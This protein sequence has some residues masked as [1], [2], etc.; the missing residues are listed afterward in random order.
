VSDGIGDIQLNINVNVRNAAGLNAINNALAQMGKTNASAASAMNTTS[1]AT[2]QQMTLMQGLHARLDQAERDYDAIFRA[3]YRLQNVG[4]GLVSVSQKLFG[5]LRNLTD[6]WGKFEFTINRA[7]GALQVWRMEAG[8]INPVYEA[9]I[10]GV[11]GLTKQLGLFPADEVAKATYYWGSTTG[12]QVK[13]LRDLK[14][15]LDAVN[16]IMKVAALTETSYEQAIKGVYGILV[17]YHRPL[18]DVAD[19]TN[20]LFLVTQRTALEFPDL[21][22]AF[23]FV[24]PLAGAMGVSFEEVAKSLGAIG[25]AGIRGTMAGR[26]LRQVFIQLARPT[27]KAKD[28]LDGLFLS[29]KAIGKNFNDTVFP[30]GK[31]IG[32]TGFVHKLA[33]SLKDAT[34]QQ[35]LHLLATIATANELSPLV[36]LVENEIK[37]INGATDAYDSNKTSVDDARYAADQ[38]RKSWDLLSGSWKGIMGR[39]REG[40][41]II[42]LRIGRQVAD[43][44]TPT[45]EKATQFLGVVE[46]WVKRNPQMVASIT[47]VAASLGALAGIAG[48]LFILSGSLLGLYAAVNVIARG[49]APLIGIGTATLGI[50]VALGEAI[51]EN[52]G[53]IQREIV[54]AVKNFTL[55]ITGGSTSLKALQK[56]WA[57]LHSIVKDF[58]NLIVR[59]AIKAIRSLLDA[60]TDLARSPIAPML[61]ELAKLIFL[62]MGARALGA[63]LGVGRAFGI[64]T[65]AAAALRIP[66]HHHRH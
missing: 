12:Q 17:Q 6:A 43:A 8:R 49:F 1:Q 18:S 32:L 16:P 25:D 22:N 7:A 54:P 31:F 47:S 36:A 13:T 3:S 50:I 20:K 23:K 55:A 38:F 21:I 59:T 44:L 48:G 60:M 24:G 56:E 2:K 42:K 33:I 64:L 19:I 46:I 57:D 62:A 34:D 66:S 41:E 53:R 10:E 58:A 15:V 39:L 61:K 9:L 35:K 45:I 14:T 26:A 52:W 40:A 65:G 11:Y 5:E 63:I 28:A 30:D 27:A 29:T 37:V 4:Y 51:V